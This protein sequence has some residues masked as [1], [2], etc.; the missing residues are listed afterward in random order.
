MF[1]VRKAYQD[2]LLQRSL[3][4]LK[5]GEYKLKEVKDFAEKYY[6]ETQRISKSKRTGEPALLRH[7]TAPEV[8][9]WLKNAPK[10]VADELGYKV[11]G[12]INALTG[13][14]V[15][16]SEIQRIKRLIEPSI[17]SLLERCE[18]V[19]DLLR[20]NFQIE[21]EHMRRDDSLVADLY[22]R[23]HS[24]TDYTLEQ[25]GLYQQQAA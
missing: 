25:A 21:Y 16:P 8:R 3:Y 22:Y 17:E 19:D 24:L 5:S 9:T 10:F 13:D 7:C 15:L 20:N 18:Y 23:L 12:A 2:A 1:K 4:P 6:I 11:V 14:G